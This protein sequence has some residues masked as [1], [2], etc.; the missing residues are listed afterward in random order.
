MLSSPGIAG[1]PAGPQWLHHMPHDAADE[2]LAQIEKN[3]E[4]RLKA[5]ERLLGQPACRQLGIYPIPQGFKLSVVIPVYNEKQWIREILRRVEE[6]PIPKEIIL[7]DDCSKDGTR[8]IL[9]EIQEKQG[10]K[11]IFQEVNQG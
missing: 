10:H 1:A 3:P 11:V 9:Q 5:L 8:E 4:L 7:V 2:V 6:V